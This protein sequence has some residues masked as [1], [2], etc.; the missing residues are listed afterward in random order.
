MVPSPAHP[1]LEGLEENKRRLHACSELTVVS[2][3]GYTL[4]CACNPTDMFSKRDPLRTDGRGSAPPSFDWK[5]PTTRAKAKATKA[6]SG[7]ENASVP[8][9]V[10]EKLA[11]AKLNRELAK[12]RYPLTSQ[13]LPEEPAE[14]PTFRKL[15]LEASLKPST[16]V[17]YCLKRDNPR[18][19][20]SDELSELAFLGIAGTTPGGGRWRARMSAGKAADVSPMASMEELAPLAPIADAGA[21]EVA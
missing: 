19:K 18:P 9:T 21:V 12:S 4:C 3:I 14:E 8:K 15:P 10:K 11:Q 7:K 2:P 17:D 16:L 1:A 5:M 13:P 6:P 20:E